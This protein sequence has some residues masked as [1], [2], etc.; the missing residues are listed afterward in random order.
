MAGIHQPAQNAKQPDDILQMLASDTNVAGG[1]GDEPEALDGTCAALLAS[2]G[3]QGDPSGAIDPGEEGD[4]VADLILN[5]FTESGMPSLSIRSEEGVISGYTITSAAGI[6]SGEPLIG[7]PLRFDTD[8]QLRDALF[9]MEIQ[10]GEERL[11]G[12][13]IGTDWEILAKGGPVNPYED[14]TFFYTL[15]GTP[16]SF[17]GTLIVVPEPGTVAMLLGVAGALLF[18]ALRR[19]HVA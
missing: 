15:S 2:L 1:L 8:T 10:P 11:L 5:P 9:G 4:G 14:L 12:D 6:F 13:V 3:E 17:T 19:R 16:G 7:G 18:L